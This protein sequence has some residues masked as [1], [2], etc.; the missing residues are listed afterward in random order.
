MKTENINWKRYDRR[1]FSKTSAQQRRTYHSVLLEPGLSKVRPLGGVLHNWID[2]WSSSVFLRPPDEID[3]V[4]RK[5]E[6]CRARTPNALAARPAID[7]SRPIRTLSSLRDHKAP[8]ARKT[9]SCNRWHRRR[10]EA[11]NTDANIILRSQTTHL[12][13]LRPAVW[14]GRHHVVNVSIRQ[15]AVV[16]SVPEVFFSSTRR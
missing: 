15:N 12:L 5:G 10:L 7:Q 14:R 1:L 9:M 8:K 3:L 16:L 11:G 13:G 2:L 4:G 6:K